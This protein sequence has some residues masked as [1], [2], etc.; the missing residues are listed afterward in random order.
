MITRVKAPG[1]LYLAGEYA[2]TLPGQASI[3]FAVNRYM[4]VTITDT[5]DAQPTLTL[6]SDQLGHKT[7]S[8]DVL[9]QEALD[10]AWNLTT[11]TLQ[12][13]AIWL[14]EHRQEL[15]GLSID[16]ASDLD[17][18]G[19]KIGL[20][21]SAATVVAL[22]KGLAQHYQLALSP[23][24]LFKMSAIIL[25]SLPSFKVGSMGDVAAAS[26]ENVIFYSRF[27][28]LWL[29]EKLTD[30]TCQ[31]SELIAM[32][33][34]KLDIHEITFP[35]SWRLVVGWT[36]QPADTQQLLT[37]NAKVARIYKE[38]LGSKTTPLIRLLEKNIQQADYI[39]FRTN[40]RL[41][42][43]ALIKFAEFMHINYV[44]PKLRELLSSAYRRGIAAKISGAGNGDNG[45]AI[46]QDEAAEV[47]L[48]EAWQARGITPLQLEIATPET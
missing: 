10:D 31:L 6:A 22:I 19:K 15:S 28:N 41:N 35:A 47:A 42:Q 14:N 33:W 21:S 44:T 18:D 3:I 13:M 20:G 9:E 2:I 46:V 16:L 1:K 12:V 25:S 45:L 29:E 36:G 40:L 17:Q 4:S 34:P 39:A 8:L 30:A 37:I 24:E 23:L 38:R 43:Q 11:K 5:D 27:D 48:K 26:F 32:D 7:I